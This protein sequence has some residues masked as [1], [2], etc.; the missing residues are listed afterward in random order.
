MNNLRSSVQWKDGSRV[1]AKKIDIQI[2]Q[3][4]KN[5]TYIAIS[6]HISQQRVF[7][8]KCHGNLNIICIG[9]KHS[10]KAT[11]H[12]FIQHLFCC[13]VL[14]LCDMILWLQASSGHLWE[15]LEWLSRWVVSC[16]LVP[17]CNAKRLHQ[18]FPLEQQTAKSVTKYKLLTHFDPISC[19]FGI[20]F[21]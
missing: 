5:A 4:Q 8:N 11:C 14:A 13:V 21:Q 17:H 12:H 3:S 20:L 2:N 1:L 15:R 7:H 6:L 16:E 18:S 9:W 10:S 19:H